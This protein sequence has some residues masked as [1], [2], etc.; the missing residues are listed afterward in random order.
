MTYTIII[1]L[2]AVLLGVYIATRNLT[3]KLHSGL[4]LLVIIWGAASALITAFSDELVMDSHF[5]ERLISTILKN[6]IIKPEEEK[7]EKP[8]KPIGGSFIKP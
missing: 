1:L 5:S 3:G 2:A 4:C 8:K 6:G 7:P